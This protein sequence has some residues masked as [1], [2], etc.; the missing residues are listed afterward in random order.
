MLDKLYNYHLVKLLTIY[1]FSEILN[2]EI[3]FQFNFIASSP[4]N[5]INR[6]E[7]KKMIQNK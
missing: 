4:K 1:Y 2:L 3:L 5:Q 6:S 7:G